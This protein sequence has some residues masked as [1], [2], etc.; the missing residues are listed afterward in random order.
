MSK[1]G[2]LVFVKLRMNLKL[3][4]PSP[5]ESLITSVILLFRVLISTPILKTFMIEFDI[6]ELKSCIMY[7]HTNLF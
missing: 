6:S 7:S 2:D 3:T 4:L 1:H 5:S